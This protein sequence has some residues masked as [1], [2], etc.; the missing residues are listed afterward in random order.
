[1][2][3]IPQALFDIGRLLTEAFTEQREWELVLLD[4]W[5]RAVRDDGVRR[6]FLAHRRALRAAIAESI[7]QVLRVARPRLVGS[8]STRS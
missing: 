1:M 2:R 7:Q 3:E 5:R 8:A 4:Y 6:E